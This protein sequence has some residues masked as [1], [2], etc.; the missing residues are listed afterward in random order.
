MTELL[1]LSTSA[2]KNVTGEASVLEEE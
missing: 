1:S 2:H